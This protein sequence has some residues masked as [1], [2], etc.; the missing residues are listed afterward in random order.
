MTSQTLAMQN[1]AMREYAARRGWP[2]ALQVREVNSGAVRR[3]A[4]EKLIEA[5]CR[6]E[7]DGVLVWRLDVGAVDGST[8][9]PARNGAL[10]CRVR[11][12]DRG[13]GPATPA[14][15]AM[16][17]LPA[18]LSEFEREVLRERTRAGLAHALENGKRLG[19]PATA[20]IHSAEIRN[21]IVP[22]TA[23]PRLPAA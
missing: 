10:G 19:R 23:N 20:A 17:G 13:T 22:V 2:N 9:H 11:F 1:R 21:Y 15:R 12:P 8:G 4:R 14:G 16:A 18:I 7:I 3:E 5:A 6:R